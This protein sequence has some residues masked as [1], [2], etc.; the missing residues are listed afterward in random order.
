M[1]A[2][3]EKTFKLMRSQTLSIGNLLMRVWDQ[4]AGRRRKT[5]DDAPPNRLLQ[6]DIMNALKE[7]GC[8]ICS[9]QRKWSDRFYYW[10]L[11]QNYYAGTMPNELRQSGGFCCRHAEK[12]LEIRS[13][14][15]TSVIYDYL[16]KDALDKLQSLAK[17]AQQEIQLPSYRHR[18]FSK[19]SQG[20]CPACVE[21]RQFVQRATRELVDMLNQDE[22]AKSYRAS[23]A[24]C[25]PHFNYAVEEASPQAI[26]VLAEVQIAKLNALKLD[27]AEYFRKVDY[28]FS[29]EP[30]G[31]EQTTW[32]RAIQ[33]FIG[34]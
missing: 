23:D 7:P 21:E 8:P 5:S 31:D 33:R 30:K 34:G 2:V 29:N 17:E 12:L 24:L 11:V 18:R 15:T 6:R 26:V 19:I 14:Y 4:I 13:V 3:T 10:L 1:E 27:F 9:M 25:M 22:A 20:K 28:R 32:E 16:V